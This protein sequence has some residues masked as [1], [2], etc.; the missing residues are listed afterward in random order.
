MEEK[1]LEL[2]FVVKKY[3]KQPNKITMARQKFSLLQRRM[4][5]TLI[6]QIGDGENLNV[7]DDG[8]VEIQI[9]VKALNETNY[10]KVYESAKDMQYL[11]I[12][13]QDTKTGENVSLVLFPTLKASKQGW[14]RFSVNPD[15]IKLIKLKE[16]YTNYEYQIVMKLRSTHSQRIYEN[17]SRWKDK[18]KWYISIKQLRGILSLE[19]KYSRFAAFEERVLKRAEEEI[20][21]KTELTVSYHLTTL[22]LSRTP[23]HITWFVKSKKTIRIEDNS[24]DVFSKKA[25]KEIYIDMTDP[26]AARCQAMLIERFQIHKRE[27]HKAVIEQHLDRFFTLWVDK[28]Y[29]AECDKWKNMPNPSG[30][31]ITDLGLGK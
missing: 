10:V 8:Q 5:Y 22:D 23:T 19:D 28:Y 27:I 6:N 9:P 16:G 26:R 15:L 2:P 29:P 13:Y 31:L 1:Q 12:E 7:T 25:S 24:K 17:V 20:N 30:A 21:E 11:N 4:Y 14:I 18:G 3:N